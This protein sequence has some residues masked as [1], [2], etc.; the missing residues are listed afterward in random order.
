MGKPLPEELRIALYADRC[1]IAVDGSAFST[2][3]VRPRV[4]QL[5]AE[6]VSAAAELQYRWTKAD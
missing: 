4:H 3:A 6:A 2:M 5:F 1:S